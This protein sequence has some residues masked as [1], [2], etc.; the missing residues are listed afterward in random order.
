[1]YVLLTVD[2]ETIAVSDSTFE[3]DS[4]RVRERIK[5][6]AVKA[7]Q[8]EELV[9]GAIDIEFLLESDVGVV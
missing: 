4:D 1:V 7:L 5:V 9:L 2:V 8:V 3:Q 6:L